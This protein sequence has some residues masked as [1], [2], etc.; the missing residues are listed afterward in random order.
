MN[1]F[2]IGFLIGGGLVGAIVGL[3]KIFF[4]AG[5][6]EDIKK[7]IQI[8]KETVKSLQ[9][10]VKAVENEKVNYSR[11]DLIDDIKRNLF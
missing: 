1:T 5:K 6:D 9:K 3:S 11:D 7:I 10:K 4:P 2:S 8:R